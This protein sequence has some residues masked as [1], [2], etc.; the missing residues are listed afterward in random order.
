MR[1][2]MYYPE[3]DQ[4]KP[5]RFLVKT[6]SG[7]SEEDYDPRGVVFG[8]GRRL[9]AISPDATNQG[10]DVTLSH[11]VCPGKYF[12]DYGMWLTM[13]TVLAAFD[14]LP[15]VDENGREVVPEAAFTTGTAR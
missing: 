3:P 6:V 12:A 15:P 14:I 5:D 13:A 10:A 9:V 4:F 2:E 8:F 11:S 1:D 7:L